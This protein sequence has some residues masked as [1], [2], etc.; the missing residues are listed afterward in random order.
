MKYQ[1]LIVI[2]LYAFTEAAD[3]LLG[4]LNL[5]HLKKHG[6]DIPPEFEGSVTAEGI[7]KSRNYTFVKS[8]FELCSSVYNQIITLVFIFGGILNYYNNLLFD[9][10]AEYNWPFFLWGLIFIMLLS[11]GKSILSAPFNLYN[12]FGIEKRF[13]F[14][15]MTFKLWLFDTAKGFII[16]TIIFSLLLTGAF[17]LVDKMPG[18]WWLPVWGCFLLFSLVIIYIAPYVLEPMFNKFTPLDDKNL[19]KI[20]KTTLQRAGINIRGVYKMDASKRTRHSNAY[21]TGLWRV[22][23]IVVFD[24]LLETMSNEELVAVLAHEAGHCKKHHVFKNLLLFEA[25]SGVAAFGAYHA[26]KYDYLT[27]LFGLQHD[28]FFAKLILLGFV[29]TIFFWTVSLVFNMISRRFEREADDFAMDVIGSGKPL[30]SA[31]VKLS[32]DNLSNIHPQPLYAMFH[33]S[34]PPELERVRALNAGRR[35]S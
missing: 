23:R 33:Y 30:A 7:E 4:Y 25:L 5:R 17:W 9:W 10:Q 21:F 22:K 11:Y 14:N 13:G 32:A 31:L 29:A 16:S 20:I 18:D 35:Q 1:L 12:I 8:K 34:H 2:L 26:L 28:T 15:T 3:L 24:N 6:Q 27:R 19:E